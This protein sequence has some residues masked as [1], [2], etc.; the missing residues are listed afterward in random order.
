MYDLCYF[1][2]SF[3][4]APM[5][6]LRSA[7]HPDERRSL[8]FDVTLTSAAVNARQLPPPA[9]A[10]ASASSAATAPDQ[11]LLRAYLPVLLWHVRVGRRT[12][13]LSERDAAQ[14]EAQL[15]TAFTAPEECVFSSS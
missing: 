15:A 8:F 2:P 6:T 1:A 11:R 12:G 10:A 13:A 3:Y 4:F 7:D 9:A 14:L 5:L